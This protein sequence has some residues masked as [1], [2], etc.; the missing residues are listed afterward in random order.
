MK[1]VDEDLEWITFEGNIASLISGKARMGADNFTYRERQEVLIKEFDK[2]RALFERD[3]TGDAAT[4]A[5][6]DPMDVFMRG[7]NLLRSLYE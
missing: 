6:R 1:I 7:K 4:I 5:H 2:D 3:E